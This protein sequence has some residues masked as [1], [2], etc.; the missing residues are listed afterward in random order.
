M[1]LPRRLERDDNYPDV[2]KKLDATLAL[3]LGEEYLERIQRLIASSVEQSQR[4][5]ITRVTDKMPINFRHLGLI[6]RIF[7]NA[8]IIHVRR[9]PMDVCVS[10]F[11]QNLAWPFCDLEAVANYY[12]RYR[13]LMDHWREVLPNTIHDIHYESLVENQHEQSRKLI[14][15]CGLEWD[16]ACLDFANSDRAVQTPSKWQVRQP[17]YASS[18]GAW[19]R[20]EE[21]LVELRKELNESD[22]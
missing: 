22:R 5:T 18:V 10:C 17:I 1:S 7:P 6:G 12:Q 3:Q 11:K 2:A 15:A 16:D 13:R 20:Y 4:D 9:D 19:R 14:E 21:H 8:R